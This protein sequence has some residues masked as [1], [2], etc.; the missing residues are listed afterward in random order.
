MLNHGRVAVP[1][2]SVWI[3]ALAVVAAGA[4]SAISLS[5]RIDPE[6]WKAIGPDRWGARTRLQQTTVGEGPLVLSR[7]LGLEPSRALGKDLRVDAV[8]FRGRI[9]P[10]GRLEIIL[11]LGAKGWTAVF[12]IDRMRDASSGY[13]L[14]KD[15]KRVDRSPIDI[16]FGDE[17]HRVRVIQTDQQLVAEIDGVEVGRWR[18]PGMPTGTFRITS[19]PQGQIMPVTVSLAGELDGEAVT[20]TER[21]SDWPGGWRRRA[22]QGGLLAGW[23]WWL[24]SGLVA[25]GRPR[26]DQLVRDAWAHAPL[27]VPIEPLRAWLG[28]TLILDLSG[29]QTWAIALAVHLGWRAL[30]ALPPRDRLPAPPHA[31]AAAGTLALAALVPALLPRGSE[32]PLRADPFIAS[33]LRQLRTGHPFELP[34]PVRDFDLEASLRMAEDDRLDVYVACAQDR[35]DLP[36]WGTFRIA[37]DPAACSSWDSRGPHPP[38]PV[39]GPIRREGDSAAARARGKAVTLRITQRNGQARAWV[40]GLPL[41]DLASLDPAQGS[42]SLAAVTGQPVLLSLALRPVN[43][44]AGS[45]TAPWVLLS[46]LECLL[47]ALLLGRALGSGWRAGLAADLGPRVVL[48]LALYLLGRAWPDAAGRCAGSAAAMF[49]G[50]RMW[51]AAAHRLTGARALGPVMA[52]ALLAFPAAEIALRVSTLDPHLRAVDGRADRTD[53][54][55]MG[56]WESDR[57][58]AMAKGRAQ[59]RGG[60]VPVTPREEER[61]LVTLGGSSVWGDG[62]RRG[63]T[64]ASLLQDLLNEAPDGPWRVINAAARGGTIASQRALLEEHVMAW[65]PEVVVASFGFNDSATVNLATQPQKRD[66]LESLPDRSS[67]PGSLS[68]LRV[69]QALRRVTVT[70]SRNLR[71]AHAGPGGSR[72]LPGSTIQEFQAE[73]HA[74]ANLAARE[75]FQLVLMP[76]PAMPPYT[77]ALPYWE[78]IRNMA[79][80]P[81]VEVLPV[82]ETYQQHWESRLLLDT[83]HPTPMGH[84]LIAQLA[85]ERLLADDR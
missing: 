30:A 40:D 79:G 44:G 72:F 49:L 34:G 64:W 48:C 29:G 12:R 83:V 3:G 46:L 82:L 50:A 7:G 27:L 60:S 20:F 10:R 58:L 22:L 6:R 5:P 56:S 78:V 62:V 17:E 84:R 31:W 76:E 85:A 33:G 15:D 70:L 59:W 25:R 63:E 61:R 74:L 80:T 54:F 39:R 38:G 4:L 41:P 51:V 2:R 32:D 55:R 13:L 35:A 69:T 21:F 8:S 45:A 42:V 26:Q 36:D 37:A 81:G 77:A 53:R 73:I 18:L 9:G 28:S 47:S 19:G 43:K 75:D 16:D 11:P 24:A 14:F 68:D 66:A 67:P 52:A 23:L 57:R 65:Q 71:A 1:R